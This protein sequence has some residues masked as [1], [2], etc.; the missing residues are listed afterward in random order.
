MSQTPLPQRIAAL[1]EDGFVDYYEL[2][3][4]EPDATV[5]RLRTAINTL[6]NEAQANRD[7]RNL[8]R[9]RDY[10]ILL[11]LLP[12]A[13]T[14]LLEDENRKEYDLFRRD[15]QQGDASISFED[16]MRN[17]EEKREA[18]HAENSAVLGIQDAEEREKALAEQRA[19]EAAAAAS[20]PPKKSPS[21]VIIEEPAA[22]PAR[23]TVAGSLSTAILFFAVL[24]VLKLF[25]NMDTPIALVIAC[26]AGIIAWLLTHR[27][28]TNRT[29]V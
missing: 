15:Y 4:L 5:T 13:R 3:A 9:R 27:T 11:Q 17:F 23:P 18:E 10:Q 6:Y 26:M 2:L 25:L 19:A 29:S 1:K 14:L 24:I 7:H 12:Q 16:W 28:N 20:A 21:R 8:N 22:A